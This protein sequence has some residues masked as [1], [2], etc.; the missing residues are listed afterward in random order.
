M[1][2]G[3]VAHELRTP[4][5]N[6]RGYLEASQ[7]G[8]V[9]P[10]EETV[11]SLYEETLLLN[12]LVE[13]LQTLSLA[14]A[15]Q[16]RYDIQ[17]VDVGDILKRGMRAMQPLADDEGVTLSVETAGSLPPVLADAE[18]TGQV[19]RNLLTNALTY[20]PPGGKITVAAEALNDEVAI[21][22]RD[23]GSGVDADHAAYL[24]E[25]FYRPDSSRERNKGGSGLG[26]AIS[27]AYVAGQNGRIWLENSSD[28]GAIFTF[29]LP[30]DAN[31]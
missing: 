18:R 15:G 22:V 11:S 30:K 25:R 23:S 10:N 12:H 31:F 6:V 3:D 20:T 17:P 8:V 16:L 28:G 21:S 1:M 27:K 5:A 4:L 19:L 29:T 13:D 9:L 14:E 24:F 2:V 7:D 26:L